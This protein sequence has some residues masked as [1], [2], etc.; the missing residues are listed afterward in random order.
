[1]INAGGLGALIEFIGS[2]EGSTRVPA[3]MALGYIGGYSKEFSMAII[4]SKVLYN[5]FT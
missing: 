3:I 1:M 2:T 5:Y 4:D